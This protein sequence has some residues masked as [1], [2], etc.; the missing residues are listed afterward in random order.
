MNSTCCTTS[1]SGSAS[2]SSNEIDASCRVPLFVL[3]ISAAVWAVVS[4]VF[5]LLASLKFHSPTFLANCA[6]LTYGRVHAVATNALLYGFAIQAGLGVALWVFARIGQAKAS[7]PWLIFLGGKL[8]N[9]GVVIGVIGI[10]MGDSTGYENMEMPRYAGVFLAL[11][12]FLISFWTLVTLHN[13]RQRALEAPQWFLLAAI[14]WFPWIFSTAQLLLTLHP[15]RGV[16]QDIVNLWFSANL[17]FVWLGLVGLA[18]AFH[19]TQRLM[20]RALHSQHLALFTFWT[21]I[22]F[23]SWTGIPASAP[24]PAWMTAVSTIATALTAVT[25]LSVMVNIYHTCGRGCCSKTENPPSGKFIA[26][27]LMAFAVAWLMNIVNAFPQA[28]A[29]TRFTWFTVAESQL[30]VYG[31]FAMTMFGAIYYIVPLVTGMEWPCAKSVRAHYWLAAIGII[32]FVLPLA[33][34]GIIEG[35]KWNDPS[36]P[37]VEVAKLSLNFLRISTIGELLVLV[38]QLLLLANLIGLS[39]R[40]YRANFAPFVADATA[41]LKQAE[42]KP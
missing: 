19:F 31:F 24:V 5:G 40:Y 22:L 18:V 17:S 21:L 7:Q 14:F 36:V 30:N 3:F 23:A 4:S 33:I 8:W 16:T 20:N 13:R 26:F 28:G 25:V 15:V 1:V 38:G 27:G 9:L 34:G 2:V 37:A 32:L 41:P 39:V 29:F 6:P 10:L 42:V 11:G 35:V 12:Y